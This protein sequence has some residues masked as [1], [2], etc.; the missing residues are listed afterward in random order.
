MERMNRPSQNEDK[1][2]K[3]M[4]RD[5]LAKA[6]FESLKD[7]SLEDFVRLLTNETEEIIQ[8]YGLTRGYQGCQ[9]MSLLFNPHRLS[10]KAKG[11]RDS[12]YGALKHEW[13]ANG[14]ARA[15]IFKNFS[16]SSRSMSNAL[17]QTLQ[18][19]INGVQYVNEFPPHV[20][21][22][23]YRTYTKDMDRSKVEILDPC[24]GWG[25]RMIGAS[26]VANKYTC[27]EPASRTHS[28]L[29]KLANFI[30]DKKLN[31]N[32]VANVYKLPFEDVELPKD[33]Y[34]FALTS[35]PYYDTEEYS[36]APTNSLNRY[37]TFEEWCEKFYIPLIEKTMNALK[38]NCAFVL[39][40]GDRRY[41]LS[42]VLLENFGDKYQITKLKDHFV[43]YG[44]N[45]VGGKGES[46]YAITKC[47]SIKRGI[48]R[49]ITLNKFF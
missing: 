35:P 47:K 46:F 45:R 44:L 20:A 4:S 42:K 48:K 16:G 14:L 3:A 31:P 24:G 17:Y 29:L 32:F 36:D 43:N 28:G 23:L 41:P 11:S 8:Y 19:G 22:E 33:Y 7:I 38:P 15:L 2:P 5:Q 40:I 30:A 6:L 26:V 18:I 27:Y 21:A 25:G 9:R 49:G 39:N 37:R 12:I 13:F 1:I 34:D 10:T